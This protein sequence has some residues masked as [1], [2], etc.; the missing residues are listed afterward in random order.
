PGLFESA[1]ESCLA[2]ELSARGIRFERQKSM[3]LLYKGLLVEQGYRLDLLVEGRAVVELKCV[4]KLQRIHESQLLSY[5]K[6]SG[7]DVGLLINF[8]VPILKQGIRRIDGGRRTENP[9]PLPNLPRSPLF[10][11]VTFRASRGGR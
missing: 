1:Y 5:L 6:L 11:Y 2:Y 3:A 7:C 8:N 4:E 10:S 9:P